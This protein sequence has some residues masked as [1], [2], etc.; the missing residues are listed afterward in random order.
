MAAS[1]R[2]EIRTGI[3][4]GRP[5]RMHPRPSSDPRTFHLPPPL[6]DFLCTTMLLYDDA[7]DDVFP[8]T[9][10]LQRYQNAKSGLDFSQ[11]MEY[12][13]LQKQLAPA[14]LDASQ[15]EL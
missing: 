10:L 2:D 11:R 15:S 12:I 7:D 3:T 6:S 14:A 8:V 13:R 4:A 1:S 5:I 9:S